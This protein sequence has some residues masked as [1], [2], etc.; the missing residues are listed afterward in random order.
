MATLHIE[1][2]LQNGKTILRKPYCTQPFKIANVTENKQA[3][4]L[5]LVIMSSSPG[6]LE[7][8]VIQQRIDVGEGCTL[9]L[10]TQSYQ[11]IFQNRK[12]AVQRL[13]VNLQRGSSFTYL[14]HPIVPH[15]NAVFQSQSKIYLDEGCSMIWGEIIGCG[16]KLNGEVFQFSSYHG[17]T[18]IFLKN[19]LVVKENL[20]L[21]PK[22]MALS[23]IG[24]LEGYTHQATLVYLDERANVQSKM[25]SMLGV[26]SDTKN[27]CFGISA[28]PVNGFVARLLGTS[29]EQ[30]FDLLKHLAFLL[31]EETS[32]VK[33]Q[34]AYVA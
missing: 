15:K 6:I 2:A 32:S 18:E 31:Q 17:V 16:R 33:T 14:P 34:G 20:M 10:A 19:K 9:S 30:L 7:G 3:K 24:Q 26:L 8:D 1:T 13:C 29:A 23:G 25:E 4:N 22:E 27:S 12:G 5:S 11:R 21:K 28:L